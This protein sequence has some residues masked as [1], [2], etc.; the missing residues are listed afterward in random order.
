MGDA[1]IQVRLYST[2]PG[3]VIMEY[4]LSIRDMCHLGVIRATSTRKYLLVNSYLCLLDMAVVKAW[5]SRGTHVPIALAHGIVTQVPTVRKYL[6]R[7]T[8]PKWS[9]MQEN[10]TFVVTIRVLGRVY[11][12][13]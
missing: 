1:N 7:K 3:E 13:S 12:I 2:K 9:K 6:L 11:R 4:G 5:L 8:Q 10:V